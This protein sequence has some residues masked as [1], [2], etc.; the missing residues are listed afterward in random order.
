MHASLGFKSEE[1]FNPRLFKPELAGGALFDV[2]I[3]PA[4]WISAILGTPSKVTAHAKMHPTGVDQVTFATFEFGDSDALA[5]MQCGF[6]ACLANE[7]VIVGETG[8]I[9]VS[10]PPQ[11]PDT[12][13]ILS[14]QGDTPDPM[15]TR[16]GCSTVTTPLDPPHIAVAPGYNYVGS[17]GFTYEVAAVQDALA[18]GLTEHPEMPLH[19][20]LAMAKLFD[21]IR[22]QIGLTYPWD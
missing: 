13:T 4:M 15:L 7:V 11:A 6:R 3:Y 20:T 2:G 9:K 14:R 8:T 12:Y 5:Q 19:E 17:Q 16:G 18:R 1:D 22:R 10:R 21:E